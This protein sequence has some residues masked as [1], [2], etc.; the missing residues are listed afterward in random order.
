MHHRYPD[1]GHCFL[2]VLRASIQSYLRINISEEFITTPLRSEIDLHY[3]N[4]RPF[5]SG[6][7]DMFLAQL[8][9]YFI[10]RC[11]N[12]NAA[13]LL[14]VIATNTF[15]INLIIHR[16]GANSFQACTKVLPFP[17]SDY[18]QLLLLYVVL[19]LH[20]QHYS[21]TFHMSICTS[22]AN[23]TS[24]SSLLAQSMHLTTEPITQSTSTCTQPTSTCTQPTSTCMQSTPTSTYTQPN[25]SATSLFVQPDKHTSIRVSRYNFDGLLNY[26]RKSKANPGETHTKLDKLRDLLQSTT[27]PQLFCITESKLSKE[28]DDTELFIDG[29]TMLHADRNRHGGGIAIYSTHS[30][31]PSRV[32]YD[33]IRRVKYLC[34]KISPSDVKLIVCC[35]YRPPLSPANW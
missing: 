4:Y 18:S 2:Y 5:I 16:F 15:N 23:L 13:D 26:N 3:D 22:P 29:Y 17:V 32:Y 19:N 34:I 7:Q 31:K 25:Y 27:K 24:R 30:L 9:R 8:N 35:V 21:A 28:I 14:S 33:D 6:S 12:S 20:N 11:Y 1:N 10:N